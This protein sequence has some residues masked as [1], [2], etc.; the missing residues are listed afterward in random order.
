MCIQFYREYMCGCK[1]DE[2]FC[3]CAARYG[4]N[5]ACA[6]IERTEIYKAN[7]LCRDHCVTAGDG[8]KEI[9]LSTWNMER[10]NGDLE[11]SKVVASFKNHLDRQIMGKTTNVADFVRKHWRTDEGDGSTGATEKQEEER[12]GPLVNRQ[13]L[14]MTSQEDEDF[15]KEINKECAENAIR[16]SLA[17]GSKKS[18]KKNKKKG[19]SKKE[20]VF[21]VIFTDDVEAPMPKV[22]PMFEK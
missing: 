11:H 6:E 5:V 13:G 8:R 20:E 14:K 18:K 12:K 17:G 7:N 9:R 19:G 3:Q 10:S 21:K 16:Q 22:R 1:K 4:S 15:R 2:E